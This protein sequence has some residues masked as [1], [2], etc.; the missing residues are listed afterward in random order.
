MKDEFTHRH[1]EHASQRKT[2]HD[3]PKIPFT[4]TFGPQALKNLKDD[5]TQNTG[6][7]Y[8]GDIREYLGP[9]RCCGRYSK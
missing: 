6:E 7:G 2:E 9:K 4:F 8:K 1:N 3:H 5:N